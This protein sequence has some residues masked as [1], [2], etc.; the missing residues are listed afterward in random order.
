M[1]SVA[2]GANLELINSYTRLF[3]PFY[4]FG[5]GLIINQL[6]EILFLN[7]ILV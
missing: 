3:L 5:F 7:L 2:K 4:L 6:L 1:I